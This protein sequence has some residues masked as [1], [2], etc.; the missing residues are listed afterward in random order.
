MKLPT[1]GVYP[2][3]FE[4]YVKLKDGTHVFIRPIKPSDRDLW[5]EFYLSLSKLSKY[6]RFFSSRPTPNE[7]MIKKYTQIDY[8][9]NMALVAII[10]QDGKEKMIGVVRYVIVPD[11]ESAEL[12]VVVG[13]EWQGKGLGT[14]LLMAMLDIIIKRRIKKIVGDVFLEN[15]KMMRLMKESGFKLI[16]INEAGIRHFEIDLS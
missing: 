1:P 2:K 15:D 9:N 3:E 8:A 5:V 7:K 14:K 13:D 16:S 11:T 10:E 12:A 6:Y 4:K